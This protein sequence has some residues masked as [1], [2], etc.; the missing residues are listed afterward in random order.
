MLL[1]AVTRRQALCKG[2]TQF[3]PCFLFLFGMN[4]YT[5]VLYS[6]FDSSFASHVPESFLNSQRPDTAAIA[7]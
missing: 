5:V 1:N 7:V 3:V 4:R 2:R 6:Y